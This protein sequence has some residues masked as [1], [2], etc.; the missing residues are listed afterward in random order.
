M[1]LVINAAEA[2]ADIGTVTLSTFNTSV[3]D[4]RGLKYGISAGEYVVLSIQD[5]GSGIS[6]EDL[7]RIFEPFY[8]K[9]KMGRSGTGLGLAV[10]WNTMED[11]DGKVLVESS[12]KGTCFYLYFPV[13]ND[14][15]IVQYEDDNKEVKSSNGEHLLVVD[16]ELQLRNI[17]SQMLESCGYVVDC[18]SSGESAIAFVKD[19]PVD[20][21]VLDMLMEPG[22]NGYQTYKEILKNYPD[23]KAIIVSGFSE[24]DDVRA[25][26]KLGADGYI[27][28]PYSM[29]QLSKVVGKA[30]LN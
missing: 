28:K 19:N 22:I 20:L 25:T 4:I 12:E 24:S 8:T 30:L 3:D 14:K 29:S 23:Q 1:N 10:V 11:H 2:M 16:D 27:K 13:K 9:K 21:I 5:T 26:L 17:A 18:V 15:E 6:E 7:K